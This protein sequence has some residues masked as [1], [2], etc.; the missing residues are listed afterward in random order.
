MV[1]EQTPIQKYREAAW[2]RWGQGDSPRKL[3]QIAKIGLH[4]EIVLLKEI[5]INSD[6]QT[7][8]LE[9]ILIE[10]RELQKDEQV[11]QSNIG[12]ELVKSGFLK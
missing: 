3:T 5:G 7:H 8:L 9:A 4:P 6:I 10:L 12:V 2:R 11:A 1:S